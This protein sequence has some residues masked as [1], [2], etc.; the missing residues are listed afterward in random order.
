MEMRCHLI[1]VTGNGYSYQKTIEARD[2]K[3]ACAAHID[4]W[5]EKKFPTAMV[6]RLPSGKR[7]SYVDSR[8]ALAA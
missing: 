4:A 3:E 5:H 6:M 1:N 8:K 7:H 2:L